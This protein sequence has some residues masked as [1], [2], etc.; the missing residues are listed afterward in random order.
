MS[1]P[2][3]SCTTVTGLFTFLTVCRKTILSL[4]SVEC[5]SPMFMAIRLCP[6]NSFTVTDKHTASSNAPMPILIAFVV[7]L[8]SLLMTIHDD[9]SVNMFHCC[10]DLVPPLHSTSILFRIRYSQITLIF[11]CS[12]PSF[13]AMAERSVSLLHSN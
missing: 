13:C 9:P 5:E 8:H 6:A 11:K 4:R 2:D 10:I 12:L 3:Y 7:I 1:I